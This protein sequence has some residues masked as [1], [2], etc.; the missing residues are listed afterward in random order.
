MN[1][2][3]YTAYDAYVSA[4]QRFWFCVSISLK[5]EWLYLKNTLYF[6]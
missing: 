4:Y 6:L 5:T 1:K 2:Y 3:Y